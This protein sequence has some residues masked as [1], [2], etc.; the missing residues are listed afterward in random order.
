GGSGG[1]AATGTS[2]TI[3]TTGTGSCAGSSPCKMPSE[4]PA[5]PSLCVT[6]TCVAGCCGT[7]LA[8]LGT[9][10]TDNGGQVCN[11]SGTCIGCNTKSDCGA[12]CVMGKCNDPTVVATPGGIFH[13]CAILGDGT[14]WCWG[15]DAFGQLGDTMM[16]DRATP[17]KVALP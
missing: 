4:C 11:D 8:P 12:Y 3:D 16:M 15:Y 5:Q 14:L 7:T 2:G 1:T 6:N 13:T 9:M 10:C 17:A